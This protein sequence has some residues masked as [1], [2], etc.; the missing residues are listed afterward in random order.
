MEI[1]LWILSSSFL[2]MSIWT[3]FTCLLLEIKPTQNSQKY[4]EDECSSK[5]YQSLVTLAFN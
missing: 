1:N 3:E 4:I 5:K 2:T